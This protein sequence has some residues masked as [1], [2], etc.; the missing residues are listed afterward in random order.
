[1]K[2]PRRILVIEDD[3]G[4]LLG[5]RVNLETEGFVVATAT[6]GTTGLRRACDET[7][8]LIVL[9]LM[10]PGISGF[11]VL[12]HLRREGVA[13]PVLILSARQGE[14]DKVMGLEL[15]ADDYV[16]KP[17]SV[18]E[19]AARIRALLRRGASREEPEF[20]LGR[21]VI[22]PGAREVFR[23][24]RPVSLTPTERDLLMAL[25]RL[26]G[27]VRTRQELERE[28]WGEGHHGSPRALDNV[29]ARLRAKIEDRPSR[30]RYLRT[31]RGVG[32]R[33][34]P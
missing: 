14:V 22:R 25:L 21:T 6:E 19:L 5:L 3:P 26:P 24:G 1:M 23:D 30:P 29:M 27:R 31:V 8:D 32:Y 12:T 20:V 34:D 18:L 10:L 16:T 17:F 4:I 15:G 28:V 13:A 9:D 7:W 33:F 2:A 11:E